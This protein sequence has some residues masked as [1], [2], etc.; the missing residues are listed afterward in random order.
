[1]LWVYIYSATLPVCALLM[2]AYPLLRRKK[3]SLTRA[4]RHGVRISAILLICSHFMVCGYLLHVIR[5]GALDWDS[6]PLWVGWA[7]I[8]VAFVL[9]CVVL[10]GI[11]GI[12]RALLRKLLP[13]E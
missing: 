4:L 8:A 2:F 1:M 10:A 12:C 9:S 6:T 5:S 11:F 7:L 3:L 13:Q